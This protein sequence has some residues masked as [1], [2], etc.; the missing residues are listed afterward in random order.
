M[1]VD[2]YNRIINQFEMYYP[3]IYEQVID[4]WGSG[5][6]SI[7][8]KLDNGIVYDYDP[9]DNSIRQ[10]YLGDD[11]DETTFRKVFG[12]NIQK[13]LP[14]SGMTK[15]ELAVKVGVSSVMMSKYIQGKST[16]SAVVAQRIANALG[17]R[18][19]DLFDEIH[20]K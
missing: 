6:T 20:I 14:Y 16:P 10:V 4:W 2:K 19:S 3:H 8:V 17:C 5:R 7:A 11:T 13:M 15:S 1:N 12:S 18:L 9:M